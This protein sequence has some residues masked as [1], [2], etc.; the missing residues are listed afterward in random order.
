MLTSEEVEQIALSLYKFKTGEPLDTLRDPHILPF[1]IGRVV[2]VSEAAIAIE[3]V[4]AEEDRRSFIAIGKYIGIPFEAGTDIVSEV[5]KKLG[6]ILSVFT[7]HS[8]EIAIAQQ[9]EQLINLL[10]RY[11]EKQTT[12]SICS[13]TVGSEAGTPLCGGGRDQI[14]D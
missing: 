8:Q 3:R 4:N 10:E 11:A 1:Y 9:I 7:E 5:Y 13:G 14:S 2:F 6:K 12:T